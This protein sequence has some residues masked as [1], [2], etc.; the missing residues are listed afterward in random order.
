MLYKLVESS[1]Y[2]QTAGKITI[3]AAVSGLLIFAFIFLFNAGKTEVLRV[4]AQSA[5]TTTLTVLNIP[6][7]WVNDA[8]ERFE[9]S[10]S[11]PTNSGT[12]VSWQATA[13]NNGGQPYYL[14][15]CNGSATPTANFVT[16]PSCA[17]STIQW[18]VSAA[19]P[20]QTQAVVSTTT[21][22]SFSESNAW[23]AFVCDNDPVNPRCN[24][25][26]KQGTNATNSSPFYVNHRPV[27]SVFTNNS[28]RN[29]S[30]VITFFSTSTDSD[31]VTTD[32][33]LT[34]VLCRTSTFS[35]T[36]RNCG[37][38][39]L[40]T[41]SVPVTDNVST[42]FTL[43]TI[44]AD[45]SYDAFGFLIDEH[46]HTALGGQ[47]GVNLPYVVGNVAPTVAGG[48]IIVNNGANITLT[49]QAGQT[50]G[51][52]LDFVISDA[53][54]CRNIT[55]TADEITNFTASVFRSGLGTTTC[56]GLPG[57]YNPNNC[58]SN[59][60]ATSTWNLFCTASSTSCTGPGDSDQI[61]NC[62]FPLWYVA[63]PTDTAGT[64][65][66]GGQTWTAAIAGIDNNNATGTKTIASAGV[67]L[68]SYPAINLLTAEIPFGALEPGTNTGTLR[69]STTA[70]AVGNTGI[71][72]N[73]SGL[74]MC[75]GF[76]IGN[77]CSVSASSTVPVGEQEF[78]TSTLAYG[79]GR[80]LASSSQLLEIRVPK[81]TS[82]STPNQ[83]LTYWGI[84]VPLSIT[85]AGAYTGLNTF[86]VVASPGANW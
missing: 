11:T 42:S 58:Y 12:S 52:R 55:N 38:N 39:T 74:G 79:T 27:F 30:E 8:V 40:A 1:R 82:T 34:L 19:T 73:L 48:T 46:G 75:P 81:S 29:P 13:S 35:T 70:Q 85:V 36:T 31:V 67:P 50:T 2:T 49:T 7:E 43:P 24:S 61:F 10:T 20:E 45:G 22:E 6:P 80:D 44:I 57:S 3:A 41:S 51:Y 54:S 47:Q 84:N 14:L 9:S 71:N 37:V 21:L 62:T 53:N 28:P 18:G 15:I 33:L 77:P 65:W 78:G 60:V 23:F 59:S 56:T 83:G 63:Q 86:S 68:L 16:A 26:F 66:D 25:T 32:D 5:A 76:T 72:Q 64:G 4:E 17:T 69:A